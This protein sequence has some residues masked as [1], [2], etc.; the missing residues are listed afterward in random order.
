MAIAPPSGEGSPVGSLSILRGAALAFFAFIGFEDLV[1]VAEEAKEP[2]KH[3]PLAIPLAAVSL[4][5]VLLGMR[6]R[7]AA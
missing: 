2:E 5:V 3:L 7:R 6:K 4:L 1:N